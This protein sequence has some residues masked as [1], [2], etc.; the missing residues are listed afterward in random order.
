M[1]EETQKKIGMEF[2]RLSS[3]L[4]DQAFQMLQA[5]DTERAR[6][7]AMNYDGVMLAWT[8]VL[9]LIRKLSEE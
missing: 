9:E 3:G 2:A 7:L 1:T 8:N 4:R 5:G 6:I